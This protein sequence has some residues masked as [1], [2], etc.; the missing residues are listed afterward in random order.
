MPGPMSSL[1]R[2]RI[3]PPNATIT[4]SN[5]AA[6]A[7]DFVLH[8]VD[9][10]GADNVVSAGA[11]WRTD[12]NAIGGFSSETAPHYVANGNRAGVAT[13]HALYN[14]LKA[15][16]TVRVV[17][18]TSRM[19]AGAPGNAD[20]LFGGPVS[21]D[22]ATSPSI[23]YPPDGVVI[24]K[25]LV[26]MVL[27]WDAPSSLDVFRMTLTAPASSATIYTGARDARLTAQEWLKILESTAPN[28]ITLQISGTSSADP[29]HAVF[30]SPEVHIKVADTEMRGTI[31]YWAVNVGRILRIRPGAEMYEDFFTP[32]PED[33]TNSTCVGCHTLSRDGSKMAFE[34][35]GGWKTQGVINTVAPTPP[36]VGPGVFPGNFAAFNASGDK[37]LSVSQ[38]A[39]SIRDPS[40]GAL[41][42]MLPTPTLATHPAWSP[43]G[44]T[45]AYVQQ[46]AGQNFGDVDFFQSDLI[47]VRDASGARM[48][49]VTLVPSEGMASTYPSFSPDSKLIAFGRGPYSRSHTAYDPMTPSAPSPG[50]IWLVP[51]DG[52]APPVKLALASQDSA[53]LPAFSPFS[54]GGYLWLAFFSRRDYGHV[55]RG[56]FGRQIWVSAIDLNAAPGADA[57]HPAFWLPAQEP[58]TQNLSAYWAPD[59]CH[60]AGDGCALDDD[61]CGGTVCRPDGM[62]QRH[63]VSRANACREIGEPCADA[64]ECCPGDLVSCADTGMG[65]RCTKSQL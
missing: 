55:T 61:C 11:L 3:D 6:A 2:L 15:N 48:P 29:S 1:T 41:L 38:G 44:A 59:P 65:S 45:I 63:C 13:I 27:Q 20:S 8:A 19:E 32:P 56:T 50:N 25:N 34:Y 42:E 36:V 16:A 17:L 18:A 39:L 33:M 7:A 64:S 23:V 62:G 5:G 46:I 21:S 10:Q 12:D 24:P 28:S 37:L 31:Y 22:P 54:G 52:S 51:S 35:Y 30:S 40:T 47:V 26:P 53:F 60:P 43:D 14:G 57:S 58:T 49:P 4:V 9:N